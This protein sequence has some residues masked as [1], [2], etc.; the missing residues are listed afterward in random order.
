MRKKSGERERMRKIGGREETWNKM[1]E[2][3]G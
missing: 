3:K 1:E 2:G